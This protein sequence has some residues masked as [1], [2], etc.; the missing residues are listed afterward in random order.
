MSPGDQQRQSTIDSSEQR[1]P[2]A[3]GGDGSG[4]LSLGGLFGDAEH[5]ADFRPGSVMLA[6][7]GDGS[8]EISLQCLAPAG[9]D[10][11]GC[12]YNLLGGFADLGV[13][14]FVGVAQAECGG[15]LHDG[16]R[17]AAFMMTGHPLVQ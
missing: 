5:G 10:R 1:V 16:R 11:G 15:G 2:V 6:G 9:C 13:A 17:C 7:L 14:L 3:L 8:G 12:I 4:V